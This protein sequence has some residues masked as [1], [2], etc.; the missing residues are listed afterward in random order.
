LGGTADGGV[1][2]LKAVR[3]P[4]H[5]KC[6][7][8]EGVGSYGESKSQQIGDDSRPH[9]PI[10]KTPTEIILDEAAGYPVS[11]QYV[12][13][14]KG[15]MLKKMRR[16]R[17]ARAGGS[18]AHGISAVPAALEFI[19]AAGGLQQAKAALGTLEEIGK[20]IG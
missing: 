19:K 18:S 14:I 4:A 10:G 11:G 8:N 15:N 1:S 5:Q 2:L 17:K 20:V 13:T 3:G 7:F 16:R 6:L 12:S 9:R